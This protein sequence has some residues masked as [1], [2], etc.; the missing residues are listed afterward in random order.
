MPLT[1]LVRLPRGLA[2]SDLPPG[3]IDTG[4]GELRWS[5][6]LAAEA[7]RLLPFWVRL[8]D[9]TAGGR[10]LPIGAVAVTNRRM[11]TATAQVRPLAPDLDASTLGVVPGRLS[12]PGP[13]TGT[14]VLRNGG[15]AAAPGA[16][17]VLALPATFALADSAATAGTLEPTED[18][19]RWSGDLAPG[20][21]V[22]VTVQGR[23]DGVDGSGRP[24]HFVARVL[25]DAGRVTERSALALLDGPDLGASLLAGPDVPLTAG[26]SFTLTARL[27]NRGH[28]EATATGRLR[29]P[30][31]LVPL[32]GDAP[33]DGEILIGPIAIPPGARRDL[34]L[35]LRSSRDAPSGRWSVTLVLDDGAAPPAPVT[36]GTD[37]TLQRADLD[38][39]R[40]VLLPSQA[41]SGDMVTGTVLVGNTGDVE[42]EVVVA[43]AL[44]PSLG[45]EPASVAASDG[46]AQPG[47][48][49]ID[50][51]VTAPPAPGAYTWAV[52]RAGEPNLAAEPGSAGQPVAPGEGFDLGVPFP[53]HTQVYTRA[54]VTGDGLLLFRPPGAERPGG[55]GG[56]DGATELPPLA[57]APLW[58]D[59]GSGAPWPTLRREADRVTV[60]WP[61]VEDEAA[62]SVTLRVDGRL[63]F[64]YGEAVAPLGAVA[65][66][67]GDEAGR[68]GLV[69]PADAVA[70]G[71][72][73]AFSPPVSWRW[74]RFTARVASG[75]APNSGVGH[76]A[77]LQAAGGELV[78]HGQI[79]ANGLDL[80]ASELSVAPAR[81]VPGAQVRYQL[82]LVANGQ[83]EAR[84]AEARV[85]LPDAAQLDL[86]SLPPGMMPDPD[87]GSLTWRGRLSP[88]RPLTLAW[89]MSLDPALPPGARVTAQAVVQAPGVP[90]VRR[91][92]STAVRATDFSGSWKRVD[93]AVAWPGQV[94]SFTLRAVNAGQVG[95]TVTL[96]DALPPGLV[97]VPGS[98][99][100]SSGPPPRWDEGSRSLRWSG[101]VA[102]ATAV[103]V[104]FQAWFG[105]GAVTNVMHLDDGAGTVAAF[106]ADVAEARYRVLLPLVTAGRP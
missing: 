8:S 41:R 62:V 44:P 16:T 76:S 34:A 18:G 95:R 82:Q 14:L 57:V 84:G 88:D 2:A 67:G 15:P 47:P 10:P 24:A 101:P 37:V 4:D 87:V 60:T 75:L 43:D 52:A 100:A 104:T 23:L 72:G 26:Q 19:V 53:L 61:A 89:T 70:P 99:S 105:S 68:G 73:I 80:D 91:V 83:V 40:A 6:Q 7:Q 63:G 32:V 74:L 1:L 64:T 90:T 17:A 27:A 94:L 103:E 78:R 93:R 77:W 42:A 36:L 51:S 48:A 5:G 85:D 25:D 39:S 71:G 56:P 98:L 22:T 96:Q 79:L 50:W 86:A 55:T 13:V 102:A 59:R 9:S 33:P 35:P 38:V 49:A 3:M 97:L 30:P 69:L 46:Q 92:A 81:P 11:L 106:W 66:V 29:L 65:G 31:H 58:R 20:V 12:A 21:A 54:W 28:G 45:L